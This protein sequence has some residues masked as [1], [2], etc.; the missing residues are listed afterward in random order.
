MTYPHIVTH[1]DHSTLHRRSE[2]HRHV[3][4]INGVVTS[5]KSDARPKHDI[6][7]CDNRSAKVARVSTEEIFSKTNLSASP[8]FWIAA[9]DRRGRDAHL[10]AGGCKY[11]SEDQ[12]PQPVTNPQNVSRHDKQFQYIRQLH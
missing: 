6:R 8:E 11:C 9:H 1:C 4:V 12:G 7:P 3:D 5:H 10:R 2:P